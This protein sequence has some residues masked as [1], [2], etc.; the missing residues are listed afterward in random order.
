[1][2]LDHRAHGAVQNDDP[3]LQEIFQGGDSCFFSIQQWSPMRKL[4]GELGRLTNSAS[5]LL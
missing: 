3:L 4:A 5:K 2:R 1:M